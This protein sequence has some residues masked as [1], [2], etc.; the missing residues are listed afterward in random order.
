[1][2]IETTLRAD[3]ARHLKA[4]GKSQKEFSDELG[5]L[6]QNFN[7]WMNGHRSFPVRHIDAIMK[8]L[9]KNN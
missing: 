8:A 6:Y 2:G 3:V 5:I 1:M 9:S 7:N 4:T